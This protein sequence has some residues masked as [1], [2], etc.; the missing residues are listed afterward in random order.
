LKKLK[1]FNHQNVGKTPIPGVSRR[2]VAMSIEVGDIIKFNMN[3]V[4]LYGIVIGVYDVGIYFIVGSTADE[5]RI[6]GDVTH[7]V[8]NIPVTFHLE[9]HLILHPVQLKMEVVDTKRQDILQDV[10]LNLNMLVKHDIILG[11]NR[12]VRKI[13]ALLDPLIPQSTQNF[14]LTFGS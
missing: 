8:R 4:E 7:K 5:R 11:T 10:M 3:N 2:E 12:H 6:V 13:R 1:C 14:L 9:M